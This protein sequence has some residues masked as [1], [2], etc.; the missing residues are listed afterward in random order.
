MTGLL[1]CSGFDFCSSLSAPGTPT[2][3]PFP[4]KSSNKLSNSSSVISSDDECCTGCS[5][6]F[7]VVLTVGAPP[8]PC[9][10]S[11]NASNSSSVISSLGS[12]MAGASLSLVV[13]EP[14]GPCKASSNSS[15]SCSV[16]SSLD[17]ACWSDVTWDSEP[18]S[19]CSVVSGS[20]P[21]SSIAANSCS[22]ASAAFSIS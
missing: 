22:T 13:G 15:N 14:P 4:C 17:V 11:S 21:V 3:F 19:D 8:L 18:G 6:L 10:S 16:I 7:S 2:N 9:N 1:D 20:S 5:V 12:S